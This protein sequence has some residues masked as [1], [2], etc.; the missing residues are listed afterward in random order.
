MS[1]FTLV[2]RTPA[3][4]AIRLSNRA[5][6]EKTSSARGLQS[7]ARLAVVPRSSASGDAGAFDPYA[8]LGVKADADAV[9]VKRAYNG[10]QMLY[11]GEADKLA[12]VERAYESILQAG[13]SARLSGKGPA[14]ENI[15]F[16]DK[17]IRS[18]WAPRPCASPMKDIAVNYGLTM[19]CARLRSVNFS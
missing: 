10:K 13:L 5:R 6:A 1:A 16:A 2:A 17:V 19:G 12:A 18:K 3:T 11:K 8:V 4:P 9:A 15:R 14:D 7:S